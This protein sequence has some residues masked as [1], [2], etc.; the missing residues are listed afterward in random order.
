MLPRIIGMVL[1]ILAV[2]IVV[3]FVKK[4]ISLAIGLIVVAGIVAAI[5]FLL[6]KKNP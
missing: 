5:L 1:L 3:G 6:K 2:L 4:L